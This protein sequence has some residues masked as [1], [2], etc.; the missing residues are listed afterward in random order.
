MRKIS[1][2]G[3]EKTYEP[4]SELVLALIKI[5]VL[6][7]VPQSKV[8]FGIDLVI[9]KICNVATKR[10]NSENCLRELEKLAA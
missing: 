4:N 8:E 3:L 5:L 6:S 9:K 7:F 10:N 2:F 1:E